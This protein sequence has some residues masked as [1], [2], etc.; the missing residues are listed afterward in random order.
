MVRGAAGRVRF[1]MELAGQESVQ[2]VELLKWRMNI[3][4]TLKKLFAAR[5]V[6]LD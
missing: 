5:L 6:L 4:V 3:S 1:S 2:F